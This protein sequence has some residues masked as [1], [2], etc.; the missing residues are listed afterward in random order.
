MSIL[1]RS[2]FELAKDIKNGQLTSREVLEFYLKRVEQFNPEINAVVQLDSARARM[3][4]DEADAAATR[5]EDWGPLHGVPLTIKDAYLTEGIISANG[6]PEYKD[7]LPSRNAD[8][9]Q[10]YIDAGAIVLGKT[11]TPYASGDWQSF[12]EIYGTTNNPWDL[13]RTCGGSS[14][15]A[16]AALASGMT[17]LELGG[18]I[19]G[20]IRI[21][22]H[23][24]GVFGHKPSHGIVSQRSLVEPEAYEPTMSIKTIAGECK[25]EH[26]QANLLA[27]IWRRFRPTK[28]RD[29]PRW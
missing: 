25:F 8:G 29:G 2:A 28:L 9:V 24:N 18:D 22:S 17:P 21:P 27:S 4:A 13:T 16:G 12:N 10:R 5:G 14:G 15:G 1:Y 3:R 26:G 7:N 23:F 11:N 20:S 6:M 19:G